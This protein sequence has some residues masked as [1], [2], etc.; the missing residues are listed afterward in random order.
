MSE[1]R[2]WRRVLSAAAL[3]LL[4][5]ACGIKGSLEPPPGASDEEPDSLITSY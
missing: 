2:G 1:H 4:V 3:A 5:A